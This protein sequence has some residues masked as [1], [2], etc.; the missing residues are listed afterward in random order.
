[1]KFLQE[2]DIKR[3]IMLALSKIPG[4]RIFNAP[5]GQ[6]WVGE[7]WNEQPGFITLKNP[8]RITF[9]LIKGGADLI[10]WR[11]I[12]ITPEMIGRRVA[13]F[14]APEIKRPGK[15]AT[16]DQ[17]NFIGQV[18]LAGGIAFVAHSEEE[19]VRAVEAGGV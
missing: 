13:V 4:V 10:G 5:T 19:A 18:N 9:G 7:V 3:K 16:G 6:A 8:R 1:M 12:V 2:R 17:E 14:L 15:R 11:S